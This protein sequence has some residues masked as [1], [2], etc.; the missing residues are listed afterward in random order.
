MKEMH[1][2]SDLNLMR[3]IKYETKHKT[4]YKKDIQIRPVA[5]FK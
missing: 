5:V 2:A 1:S 3:K 4:K